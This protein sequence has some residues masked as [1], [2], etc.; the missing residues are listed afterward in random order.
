[1]PAKDIAMLQK[2]AVRCSNVRPFGVPTTL[3]LVAIHTDNDPSFRA[4][5]APLLRWARE[6]WLATDPHKRRPRDTLKYHEMHEAHAK[7]AGDS[8]L[9]QGP[10]KAI[11]ASLEWFGWKM[12]MAHI[13]INN[14]GD[15]LD[16]ERGSPAMLK[17][18]MR[19]DHEDLANKDCDKCIHLR[20]TPLNED[21]KLDWYLIRKILRKKKRS[22][23]IKST[24][25]EILY[26]TVPTPNWLW[27]HGW[28]VSPRC[29][30][31]GCDNNIDHLAGGCAAQTNIRK[32]V[33]KA[34]RTVAIPEKQ[35]LKPDVLY[36]INGWPADKD[37]FVFDNGCPIYTDG[38]A[39]NVQW[40]DIAV[41]SAACFQSGKNGKH[42][43]VVG[44]LPPNFPIS[45][46]ASEFYAFALAA[47]VMPK[48]G[49]MPPI[50]SDCQAVVQAFANLAR[51]ADYRSKFAG[52]WRSPDIERVI[53]CK[54]V[55]AHL[56]QQ[57]AIQLGLEEDWFGND[58]ADYWAKDTLADTWKDGIA[59]VKHRKEQSIKACH[60]AE[61]VADKLVTTLQGHPQG[62]E[63]KEGQ[64][65]THCATPVCV[66]EKK[67]GSVL[68]AGASRSP[69]PAGLIVSRVI[70]E[71]LPP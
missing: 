51:H 44:Q 66:E 14:K 47:E 17:H 27:A 62:S 42:R 41:A 45:A 63:A 20:G 23:K 18:Y 56:C 36:F 53:A 37:D 50:I 1:M 22:A 38:S 49:E 33:C 10:A 29:T 9:P 28:K 2:Q 55:K 16:M 4:R 48:S 69:G 12:P 71:M 43:L 67:D 6:I 35:K 19:I 3:G 70:Q 25:L 65:S 21:E 64:Q 30:Q 11:R 7:I 59:Y 61:Q 46:V 60:L 24:L 31:C 8:V 13:F 15:E 39:K 26:G 54:K 5:S 52:M 34:L 32:E 57:E 58:N 40:P 68:G